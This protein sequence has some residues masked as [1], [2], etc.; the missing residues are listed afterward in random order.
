MISV[1]SIDELTSVI[2]RHPV[3]WDNIHA[4]D[5]DQQSLFLGPYVGRSTDLVPKLNGVLTN[6]NCEYGAN[7]VPIHTLAQ[8]CKCGSGRQQRKTSAVLAAAAQLENE[9]NEMLE[10][11]CEDGSSYPLL[12][13]PEE[14][15]ESA[16][17]KWILEFGISR[18]QCQDYHPVKNPRSVSQAASMEEQG[19]GDS[20]SGRDM[21]V[22]RDDH[23][24]EEVVEADVDEAGGD[25]S[26]STDPIADTLTNLELSSTPNSEPFDYDNLMTLVHF[27]YLPNKHGPRAQHIVDEFCWL[28]RH[29]PGFK[30]IKNCT[31]GSLTGSDGDCEE[32]GDEVRGEEL[33]VVEPSYDTPVEEEEEEEENAMTYAQVSGGCD[34]VDQCDSCAQ[35]VIVQLNCCVLSSASL[36]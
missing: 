3:I 16:L 6:P 21:E 10:D 28:K 5:Y 7:F 17:K 14:A 11:G 19:S 24:E 31:G 27:F 23:E 8:W 30:L 18:R 2:K 29:A 35:L 36:M 4:N 15:L 32:D 26:T 9:N 33:T 1:E 25:N 34:R 13:T 12:Y 20:D 22:T